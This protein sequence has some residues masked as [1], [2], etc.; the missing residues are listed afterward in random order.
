LT[1]TLS[2]N[3]TGTKRVLALNCGTQILPENEPWYTPPFVSDNGFQ[4]NEAFPSLTSETPLSRTGLGLNLSGVTDPA[5]MAVYQTI[6][7]QRFNQSPVNISYS[8]P[9]IPT[10]SYT[11][12]LHFAQIFFAQIGDEIFD[13]YV[14]GTLVWGAFDI[15]NVT[16]GQQNTAYIASFANISPI[17]GAIS[18][19]LRPH[20]GS[21]GWYNASICGIEVVKP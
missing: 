1:G 12:R 14:N 4:G 20:A 18:V 6:R 11:V 2:G 9:N 8:I 19:E 5:P 7:D 16:G 10:G 21:S 3:S 15:L 13:I 17:S